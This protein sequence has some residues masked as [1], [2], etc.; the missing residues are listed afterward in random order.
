[1]KP[2]AQWSVILGLVALT[3]LPG[4]TEGAVPASG[5]SAIARDGQVFLTWAETE[6]PDETTFNVY[7]SGS[8]ITDITKAKRVG[9]HI[10]RHSARDWWEDPASLKKHVPAAR[11]VGF[12]I[13][14]N[15]PRLDPQ[16]GLFV[17]TIRQDSKE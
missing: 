3:L 14:S 10:E 17:H 4:A 7:L 13:Q 5:L 11:P 6:T 2:K 12:R 15:A 16:G 8:P 9:H 1:M